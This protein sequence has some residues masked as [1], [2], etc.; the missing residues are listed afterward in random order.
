MDKEQAKKRIEKLKAE[1]AHHRYLYHVLDK[2][3]ISDAALDSLKNELFKQ[4]MEYPELITQ[5]SP[6]QR[7]GGKPLAKFKKVTHSQP[8]LSLYDAFSKQDMYDWE[9]RMKKILP[10]QEFSYYAELKM[11]GLAMSLRYEA[12]I[13]VQGATR[14][15]GKVGE[16][17]TQNLKTIDAIPLVLR[18]PSERELKV[19]GL[20]D[21]IIK[22]FFYAFDRGVIE[23]RG[24]AIMTLNVLKELNEKY[25]REGKA[26]LANPRNAAAGS[27]RQLDPK[28]TAERKLD[29]YAYSLITDLGL[30]EHEQEH[31]LAKL[32]G[33]KILAINKFCKNIE[34]V[35]EFHDFEERNKDKVP[36]ECD[37]VV[38][39]V[40]DLALWPKLGI[41]GKGP[42]YV[43]AY[44]FAA[45]QVTTKLL[46]VLWQV[47]RTGTLTPTAVLEP[48]RVGGVTV[49]QS[50]LHNMDEIN[51]LGLKIGD[52]IILERAG[53]VIP[54]VVQVLPKLRIGKEKNIEAP[55]Q[56]PI[57]NSEVVRVPGEVAFRCTNKECYAVNMRSM[58]HWASK[59]AMDIDGLG[60]KIIEQLMKI[61]L[62]RTFADFYKLTL[63]DLLPLERFA[64][65]SAENLIAAIDAKRE[66]EL[67]KFIY[68]LGIRHVG[69][70]TAIDLANH[71]G[72]LDNIKNAKLE[73]LE[74]LSDVGP[75]MAKSIYDWFS[76]P[77]HLDLLDE[78]KNNGLKIK[79]IEQK[80]KKLANKIFVLTG[81]LESFTR[82][83][84]KAKI[85][86]LGGDVSS[87]VSK[88]TDYVVAG[89]E[90]G[91]KLDKAKTLGVR[92]LSESEFLEMIK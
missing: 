42:R 85:R 31:E 8:M 7:I 39:M 68:G 59:G 27:I 12:G 79:K 78:L 87:S 46:D 1:I 22:K 36:F 48:V 38:A 92:V 34:E 16:D 13:F 80:D 84:A 37:G 43:M 81:S 20:D 24:E 6:T 18:R 61:G 44:K 11:D 71:F 62:V 41:V 15:D 28:I 50:T 63:D 32:I 25:A 4:E 29:F 47:G 9:N 60:P 76:N 83:E 21:E 2:Q 57:C 72:N 89:E 5:D 82:D 40:N 74:K 30:T 73:D 33:F 66:V 91:S 54:K 52:T 23:V 86:G 55:K 65:K 45:E 77:K 17:V 51:R 69:E 26:L 56:C 58:S 3:E 35:I 49:S 67:S 75:I 70:E 53:D 88:N 90:A 14:G 10:S 19:I 64:Q